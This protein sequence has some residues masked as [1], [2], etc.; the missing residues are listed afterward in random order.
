MH[1]SANSS[2]ILMYNVVNT[3]GFLYIYCLLDLYSQQKTKNEQK[4]L[5]VRQII[6]STLFFT[7]NCLPKDILWKSSHLEYRV[8]FSHHSSMSEVLVVSIFSFYFCVMV[9]NK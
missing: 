5:N 8:L 4:D 1:L 6:L 9:R 3:Q 2:K 7:D